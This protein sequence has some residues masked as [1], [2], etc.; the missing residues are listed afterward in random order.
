MSGA[1]H[2][3]AAAAVEGNAAQAADGLDQP[4]RQRAMLVIILGIMVA[5]L[6]G[7]IVNLA[8]PGIARELQASPRM[9][10]GWSTP[11]RSPRW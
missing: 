10:S 7:T 3:Q 11:T 9:R 6:D 1:A 4:A 5:V 8:L 2:M